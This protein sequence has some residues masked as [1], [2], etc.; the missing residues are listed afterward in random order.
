MFVF[1]AASRLGSFSRAG[2][3]LGLTQSAVSRQIG[4]LEAFIG[5]KLFERVPTGV[6]LTTIG[7]NYS[8]DIS[9]LIL[10][11]ASVRTESARGPAPARSPLPAP[12]GLRIN[13]SC[14]ACRN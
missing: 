8:I 5:S 11:I 13:G 9:R 1:E 7:E 6:R 14:L 3:E 12:A 2:N 10:D 4:K